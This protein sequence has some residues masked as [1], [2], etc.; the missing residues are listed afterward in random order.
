M[1]VSN[2]NVTALTA[3][4]VADT[5]V[6]RRPHATDR[7]V[8]ILCLT[9]Q[10]RRAFARQS[11]AHEGWIAELFAAVPPHD[12][13]ALHRLLGAV[14]TGVWQALTQDEPE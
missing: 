7:R 9:P 10:G 6:E 13:T 12:R 3:G 5:L 8:Q 1:M 4:L 11:A 14:K 2:G